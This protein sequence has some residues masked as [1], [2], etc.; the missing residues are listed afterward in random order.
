MKKGKKDF[1]EELFVYPSFNARF[2][3]IILIAFLIFVFCAYI[4]L[5]KPELI[6]VVTSDQVNNLNLLV[7]SATLVLA[8]FASYYAL[9]Q[10]VETRFTG[11][12]EAGMQELKNKNYSR[13][14]DKWKDAFYIRPEPTVFKNLC[15]SLLL[16]ED[17]N[18]FDAYIKMSERTAFFK[19]EMFTEISDQIA[20]LY[21]K[22]TRHLLVKNQGEAEKNLSQLVDLATS[23]NSLT[24]FRWDFIDLRTSRVYQDLTGECK[25]IAENM[26]A[27]LSNS[28]PI[29]RKTDF[30]AKNFASQAVEPTS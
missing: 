5:Y 6:S 11:L 29:I 1:W 24:N 27:Y 21:L 13:A 20:L 26:M 25:S 17:Y 3:T 4:I 12:D 23:N 16:M 22:A 9:R 2:W 8:I 28:M 18:R 10:L 30:E 15:E 14:F 19:K 7:Q